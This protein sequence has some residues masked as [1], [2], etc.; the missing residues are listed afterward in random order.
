M[1]PCGSE[2]TVEKCCLPYLK[3]AQY[4]ATAE[5]LMRSRYTAYVLANATY[6][7]ETTHPKTRHLYSKKS[8]VQWATENQWTGLEIV[9]A[10]ATTV[11]FIACFKDS[12]GVEHLHKEHSLFETL[13]DKLY[14]VS[15]TF[16][17]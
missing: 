14:Y 17:E 12:K 16:E 1:C 8:I 7:I 13:G 10:T 2:Q 3:G 11:T 9:Q 4:P 15:G 5:A 6:L